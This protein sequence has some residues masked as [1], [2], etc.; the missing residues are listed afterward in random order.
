LPAGIAGAVDSIESWAGAIVRPQ[1]SITYD[2]FSNFLSLMT[3]F[4]PDL[5]EFS[6]R[7]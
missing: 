2:H 5:S 7:I 4:T 3:T 6:Q 1:L